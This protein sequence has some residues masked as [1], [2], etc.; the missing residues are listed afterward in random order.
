M[1]TVL[2]ALRKL[3]REREAKLAPLEQ[4]VTDLISL[5]P[6]R[7]GSVLPWVGA[8]L[9]ALLAAS[10][11]GY[12]LRPLREG[13]LAAERPARG[14]A[15][16]SL[17]LSG[18]AVELSESPR[19]VPLG[20]YDTELAAAPDVA[21]A[22]PAE[23]SPRAEGPPRVESGTTPESVATTP[24][25]PVDPAVDEPLAPLEFPEVRVVQI[26]WHPDTTRREAQLRVGDDPELVAREGDIVAGLLVSRIRPDAVELRLGSETKISPL[27]R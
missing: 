7:R 14:S 25:A 16:S 18:T 19:R 13:W 12:S 6:P 26:R 9:A 11:V 22:R 3:Q 15:S 1:S 24:T 23:L 2:D 5:T 8:A 21:A 20:L 17:G 27:G 4:S 10:V